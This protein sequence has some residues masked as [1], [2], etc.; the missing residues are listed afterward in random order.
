VY[1][2]NS[3]GLN[4]NNS[5]SNY[6]TYNYYYGDSG[7]TSGAV[8]DSSQL[9]NAQQQFRA[10][11]AE[12]A[13]EGRADELFNDAVR[14]FENGSYDRAA[15]LFADAMRIA[16]DDIVLP[17]A[18]SQALFA[19]GQYVSAAQALR[20]AFENLPADKEDMFYPRGLYPDEE[21][22][23]QQ[24]DSLGTQV[25]SRAFDTDLQLLLGYHLVGIGQLDDAALHL[26]RA[27]GASENKPTVDKLLRLIERVQNQ[28][29][30][31]TKG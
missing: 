27:A 21:T 29:N 26:Q 1:E 7:E 3:S 30:Q 16:G 25:D 23:T 14:A 31:N 13:P 22:L 18:Y 24:I 12:P 6:Y 19:D 5:T 15:N 11:E 4:S 28:E 9:N 17:F 10:T 8:L 20:T 2:I